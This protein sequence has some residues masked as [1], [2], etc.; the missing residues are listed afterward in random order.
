MAIRHS[1][2]AIHNQ[3]SFLSRY[4]LTYLILSRAAVMKM[5]DTS[6]LSSTR[7]ASTSIGHT[8]EKYDKIYD[9]KLIKYDDV[10][11]MDVQEWEKF[12]VCLGK[13]VNGK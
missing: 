13:Q 2:C 6:Q 4:V 12:F 3:S 5:R 9:F 11:F 1:L 8:Q 10:K 7:P